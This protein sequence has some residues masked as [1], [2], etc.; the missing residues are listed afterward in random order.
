MIKNKQ[1]RQ[2][3]TGQSFMPRAGQQPTITR[4]R[5]RTASHTAIWTCIQSEASYIGGGGGGPGGVGGA[6][7][8]GIC[9]C[10]ITSSVAPATV[11]L[12]VSNCHCRIT[13]SVGPECVELPLDEPHNRRAGNIM[14]QWQRMQ[15]EW[16]QMHFQSGTV[17]IRT[18]THAIARN[19]GLMAFAELVFRVT[20]SRLLFWKIIRPPSAAEP[21]PK[22]G[23]TLQPFKCLNS[24]QWL[25]RHKQVGLCRAHRPS[26][27]PIGMGWNKM[28]RS[29][30]IQVASNS[31]VTNPLTLAARRS[32]SSLKFCLTTRAD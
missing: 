6:P 29:T 2:N 10:R 21:H 9:N 4:L 11:A 14:K 5:H 3:L 19:I 8:G 13:S 18:L 26:C 30:C 24:F 28:K 20:L 1:K 23:K 32:P 17:S 16:Q 22:L 31:P 25:P 12:N 27:K 7:G 15:H